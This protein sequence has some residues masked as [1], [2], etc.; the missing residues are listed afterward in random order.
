MAVLLEKQ[1]VE[2]IQKNLTTIYQSSSDIKRNNKL[3]KLPG[4]SKKNIKKQ[5]IIKN[6]EKEIK[7]IKQ[8]KLELN[9]EKNEK[10][11]TVKEI[12]KTEENKIKNIPQKE[13]ESP[14]IKKHLITK[15]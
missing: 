6:I 13:K 9:I 2:I 7:N 3:L 8:G 12:S 15:Q 11:K 4:D 10:A 14:K 1:V 5:L